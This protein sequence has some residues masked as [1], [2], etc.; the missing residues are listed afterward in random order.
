[1][2]SIKNIEIKNFKSIRHVKIDN[3][4]RINVFIGYPN[5][6]KSNILEAI[7]LL[8]VNEQVELKELIRVKEIPTIFFNG[9]IDGDVMVSLNDE[10][11]VFA[12]FT[13]NIF[14]IQFQE[15][16]ENEQFA[17]VLLNPAMKPAGLIKS[18]QYLDFGRRDRFQKFDIQGNTEEYVIKK[19]DFKKEIKTNSGNYSSLQYPFGSNIFSILRTNQQLLEDVKDLFK[20]YD[21][22]FLYDSREQEFTILKRTKSGIFTVP[23][24]LVADTLQRLIFFKAAIYSNKGNVLLLEEPEAHMFPPYITKFTG[25]IWYNKDN[26]FFITTHS[27]FV[28]ND[29]LENIK[30]ELAIYVVEYDKSSG[31]TAIKRMTEEQVHEAYQYGID[32]FFNLESITK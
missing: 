25:D 23:Y 27:P 9:F 18:F 12:N 14:S 22:E 31:E 10:Y 17:R 11:G 29:F 5:V 8:A 30:D 6:G 32:L 3:C 21:L 15:K 4:R 13:N 24:E 7:S 19:Y 26:Q 1:M 20:D 2:N 28:V 16:Q